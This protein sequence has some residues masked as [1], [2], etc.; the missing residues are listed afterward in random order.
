MKR[1]DFLKQ[2]AAIAP[3]LI[4]FNAF[5]CRQRNFF[6]GLAADVNYGKRVLVLVELAGGNDSLNTV[7]PIDKYSILSVARRDI[8][9]PEKKIL[10]LRDSDVFGF[11][12]ALTGLQK[13]Y[14]DKLVSVIQGV[15]YANP[16]FSHFR[17]KGIKYTANTEKDEIRSGWLGRYLQD[18]YPNYP[19]GYPMHPTDG[20]ATIRI[21]SV[22]PKMTQFLATDNSGLVED[23]SI[24]FT[25]ISDFNSS[26][27][28]P[29]GNT[30]MNSLAGDNINRIR[31]ISRQIKLYAPIIQEYSARQQNLSKLYPKEGKNPLADQLKTV[32]RLIGSGLNTPIYIVSQSDYD[33]HADQVD[34]SDTTQGKH[35]VL[36][37]NLSEAI[38][39]FQDDLHLMGKQDDVLGMTFSE[40]GRRIVCGSYG[41]D[42]GTSESTILFGTQLKNGIIGESPELPSKVTFE[43]NLP[44]QYDFR[45]VYKAV[46]SGWLGVPAEKVKKIINQG[47]EEKLE[48]FKA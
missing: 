11:H 2:T 19:K 18:R 21:G 40:F 15:G 27:P 33:T 36:L 35:A 47:P 46:L 6:Q 37:T 4:A 10:P 16:E 26:A 30:M 41:T 12:P 29:E 43:D 5:S 31:D 17:G 42:H 20:P 3:F 38:T 25:N 44:I 45:T 24:G 7:I 14:N 8:L 28:I 34:K 13:L 48:L 32:A 22:S 39:A 1:R 23:A 9:I